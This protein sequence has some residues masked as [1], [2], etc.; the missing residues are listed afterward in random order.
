MDIQALLILCACDPNAKI[1]Y[2]IS[3]QNDDLSVQLNHKTKISVFKMNLSIN[4]L[5]R[6]N[7]P[8]SLLLRKDKHVANIDDCIY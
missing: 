1:A 6:I 8:F 7:F 4:Y 3:N 2:L 5:E